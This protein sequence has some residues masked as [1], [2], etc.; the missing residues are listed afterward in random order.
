YA[1]ALVPFTLAPTPL[2]LLGPLYLAC[3]IALDAWFLWHVVRVLRERT[4]AAAR[5]ACRSSTCS[6]SSSRCSPTWP[7]DSFVGR[8][9]LALR[10]PPGALALERRRRPRARGL[11]ARGV[12][13]E[14][15]RRGSRDLGPHGRRVRA[16]GGAG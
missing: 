11:A 13:G 10:R 3:A 8:G 7:S 1:L 12:V 5:R 4:D 9:V 16:G 14:P 6:R 15:E 2:G